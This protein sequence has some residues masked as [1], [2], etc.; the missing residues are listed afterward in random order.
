MILKEETKEFVEVLHLVVEGDLP[1]S[2]LSQV[3]NHRNRNRKVGLHLEA[4]VVAHEY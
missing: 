2:A 3:D 1:G 4:Q